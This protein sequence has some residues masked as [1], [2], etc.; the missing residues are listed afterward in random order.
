MLQPKEGIVVQMWVTGIGKGGVV[1][2]KRKQGGEYYIVGY[3]G[4]EYNQFLG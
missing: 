3:N 1:G 2:R 4:G